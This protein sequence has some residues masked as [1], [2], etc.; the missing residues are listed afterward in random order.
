M[1]IAIVTDAWHPQINGVVRTLEMTRRE[2]EAMGHEVRFITPDL[3]R[4]VPCPTYPDIRLAMVTPASVALE[5]DVIDPDALH[6]ATEGPLG[7]AARAVALRRGWPF[8]TAYHSQLPEY[9]HLRTRIPTR[10]SHALLR[11]FHNASCATLVPTASI[12]DDLS[13]RGYRHCMPWSRG[14]DLD[15]FTSDG[16]QIERGHE[17]VFL[18][19]GRLAVEKNLEAFL[20]LDLPGQKW[21]VGS[22]PLEEKLKRAFPQVRWF[23]WRQG[24]ELASI[25]RSA[26]V[27]VFPSRTDTFGLV[28]IEAM[29]CGTPVAAFPVAGPVDVVGRGSIG[30]A[31]DED[32]GR[33]CLK[34]LDCDRSAVRRFALRYNWRV[35]TQQFIDTLRP[36]AQTLPPGD[37]LIESLSPSERLALQLQN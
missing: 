34:A 24:A 36:I 17:P 35:A 16:P 13:R 19:V 10:W 5:L 33:A 7:W 30:G 29:A 27:K 20:A 4:S 28:L 32:L 15:L 37:P 26:D 9:V 31:L 11:R 21:V 3:F 23:G 8:S 18:Y 14:V 1:R 12:Q 2:L 25:Y 22:G 6:I